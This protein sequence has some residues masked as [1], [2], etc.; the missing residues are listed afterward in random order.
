MVDLDTILAGLRPRG[1]RREGRE[2]ARGGVK[3]AGQEYRLIDWSSSG[4]QANGSVDA[5]KESARI[6]V[7]F[8]VSIGEQDYFFECNAFIVRADSAEKRFAGVFVDMDERDRLAVD[9]Y[10]EESVEN[11]S[12]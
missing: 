8:T 6:P 7:E 9:Q 3:I 2:A 1:R 10:F 12:D 11:C 5:L 4:F